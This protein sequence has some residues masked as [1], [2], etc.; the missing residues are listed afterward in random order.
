MAQVIESK[1]IPL[2]NIMLGDPMPKTCK[3]MAY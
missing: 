3:D 2:I 1:P